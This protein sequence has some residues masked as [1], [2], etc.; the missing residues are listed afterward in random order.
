MDKDRIP[1]S[2][3]TAVQDKM[4]RDMYEMLA[5]EEKVQW[6]EQAMEEYEMAMTR[7]RMTLK[8]TLQQLQ[9]TAKS[10][11]LFIFPL[12]IVSNCA[13]RCIQG[14]VR[15]AQPILDL[16]CDATGWKCSLIAGGPEPA[17]GGWLNIIRY[18]LFYIFDL[19]YRLILS[20][21][22]SGPTSGEVKMNFGRAKRLRY[23]KFWVPIYGNFLQ[24]CYCRL[25]SFYYYCTIYVLMP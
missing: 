2:K 18:A 16:I 3:H 11:F 13:D 10:G 15:F 9:R 14:L 22:H 8:V 24:K 1:R 12:C 19:N 6:I 20:S 7:W 17:H 21:I 4:A 5:D 23:K 25:F